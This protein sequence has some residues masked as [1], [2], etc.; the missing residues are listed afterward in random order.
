MDGM[1]QREHVFVALSGGVDSAVSAA[2]LL[3]EGHQVTGIFMETW[4]D[5]EW[6][7][8]TQSQPSSLDLARRT[9]DFLGIPFVVVDL[10][11]RF[12]QVVVKSFIQQYLDC[13]TPNPCLICNPQIKWGILQT[14]AL[15]H[16]A[17]FFATG[18]YARIKHLETGQVE[19]LRGVDRT[20]D[21]SYVLS[22][23]SQSQ[24]KKTRFP[25][26]GWT[27]EEVRKRARDLDLPTA[28]REES[29]DLCFLG[30]RDYRDFLGRFAPGSYHPGEIVDLQGKVIGEHLGLPFYTV[31]QRKGIRVAAAEPYFVV[32]K[33]LKR[34]RLVVGFANQTGRLHLSAEHANWIAGEPPKVG[35][36]YA[37][38]VRYRAKP[39]TALLSSANHQVFRL[40]FKG[41]VHGISPGQVAAL[42]QGDA[43]L[44][45]GF[46]QTAT[47]V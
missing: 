20:K 39:A 13:K 22:L 45:G 26:G 3:D 32:D 29:Q 6:E 43:C 33:D 28:D 4:K 24:L 41:E 44:G 42:Y 15:E 7:A 1:N 38:L 11:D 27:K 9:A 34:N 23:L 12:F 8:V 25:L 5:P 14:Y 16:G 46:I 47:L 2:C 36:T 37:V 18:H 31:G 17:E 19:L 35:E 40:E 10:R 21:Q 30:G